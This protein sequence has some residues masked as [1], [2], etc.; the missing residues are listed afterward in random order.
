MVQHIIH[1]CDVRPLSG[2][3][4]SSDATDLCPPKKRKQI[5]YDREQ[6]KKCVMDDWLGFI[7]KFPD[8]SFERTFHVKCSMVDTIINHLAKSDQFWRQ[9]VCRAGKPSISPHLKFL[10][11][12]TMMCYGVSASTFG[13]Y[14]QMG[15]TTSRRCLS[16]L[17]QGMVNCSALANVYLLK[18]SKSDARNVVR[19]HL[20]VHK[21]PWHDGVT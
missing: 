20:K 4:Q 17:T 2:K 1:D 12:Q 13:D 15:E 14:F 19:L 21:L 6:A 3:R 18:A 5:E 8:K 7:P 10:C 9:T 11:A 16:K